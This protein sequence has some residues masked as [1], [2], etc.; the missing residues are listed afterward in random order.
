[1]AAFTVSRSL[2]LSYVAATIGEP[3]RSISSCHQPVTFCM[4]NQSVRTE[5]Y[6]PRFEKSGIALSGVTA[7]NVP[8]RND[9]TGWPRYWKADA[10]RPIS[11]EKPPARDVLHGEPGGENRTVCAAL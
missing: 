10:A 2:S 11:P 9:E 6:V 4:A 3:R 7:M 1:M 5:R 8:G